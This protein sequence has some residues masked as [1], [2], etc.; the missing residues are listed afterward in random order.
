MIQTHDL[1]GMKKSFNIVG[2]NKI[3]ISK[4]IHILKPYFLDITIELINAYNEFIIHK[5]V[6][7]V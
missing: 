2:T 5:S 3:E 1:P 7:N 4:I 6:K